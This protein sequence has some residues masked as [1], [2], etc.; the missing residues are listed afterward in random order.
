M[1]PCVIFQEWCAFGGAPEIRYD[2]GNELSAVGAFR[3]VFAR[4]R[5]VAGGD[6][7][8]L[9]LSIRKTRKSLEYVAENCDE[10]G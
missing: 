9:I 2:V 8:I 5:V 10:N 6:C 1:P 7:L 3:A 4:S